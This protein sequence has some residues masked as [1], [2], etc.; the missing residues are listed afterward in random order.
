M[1]ERKSRRILIVD[2]NVDAAEMFGE[3]MELDGFKTRVAHDGAAAVV[4]AREFLP[5]VIFLDLGM[6][7]M[8]G[9][10][11][12]RALRDD[13]S[14]KDC[15]IVAL[16]GWDGPEDKR[17]TR[18]AGFHAHLAKPIKKSALDQVL[19]RIMKQAPLIS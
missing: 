3:L 14:L 19:A 15:L 9:F 2:D 7:I 8:D 13:P 17:K 11:V 1:P 5:D 10:E 18:E 4:A 12:A 6:P 16:S